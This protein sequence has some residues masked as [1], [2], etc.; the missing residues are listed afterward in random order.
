MVGVWSLGVVVVVPSEVDVARL[1]VEVWS[2]GVVVGVPSEVDVVRL[3]ALLSGVV[4]V[5]ERRAVV[6]DEALH[7]D[8]TASELRSDV[9]KSE[10]IRRRAILT[11]CCR[12]ESNCALV[13]GFTGETTHRRP[14]ETQRGGQRYSFHLFLP[15]L[16][17]SGTWHTNLSEFYCD[18]FGK[19]WLHACGKLSRA[20]KRVWPRVIKT[21]TDWRIKC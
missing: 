2:P 7:G 1:V 4:S 6:L 19:R 16:I 17:S 13:T 11:D 10:W 5:V 3:V 8:A 9:K 14:P 20:K 21:Y 12:V 15:G 18:L